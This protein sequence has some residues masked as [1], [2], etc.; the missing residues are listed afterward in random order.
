MSPKPSPPH[1]VIAGGGVAAVEAMLALRALA[2]RRPAI[3]LLTA[4]TDLAPPA[5]SVAAPFGFGMPATF[6]IGPLAERHG[7][8][9]RPAMLAAVDA[10]E[11]I[12]VLDDEREL[13]YDHLLVARRS[14]AR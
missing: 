10:P 9:V 4:D 6:P 11:R 13:A 3:T 2:G 12:A 1:I 14:T 8:R 7:V 5:T